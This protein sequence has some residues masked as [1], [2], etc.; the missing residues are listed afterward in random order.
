MTIRPV[1]LQA[2]CLA[3]ALVPANCPGPMGA[4]CGTTGRMAAVE[5]VTDMGSGGGF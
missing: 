1:R 4:L 5:E 3:V 2:L